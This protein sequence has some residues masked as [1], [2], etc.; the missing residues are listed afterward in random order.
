MAKVLLSLRQNCLKLLRNFLQSTSLTFLKSSFS[1]LSHLTGCWSNKTL[2]I[3][4]LDEA[5]KTMYVQWL[6]SSSMALS[7]HANQ[8]DFFI[9]DWHAVRF[10]FFGFL[11]RLC[12]LDAIRSHYCCLNWSPICHILLSMM[13]FTHAEGEESE[14]AH[15]HLL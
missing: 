4:L 6:D 11:F 1:F 13:H 15:I 2:L 14:W 7:F 8:E 12:K 9:P 3:Y 5:G 10:A